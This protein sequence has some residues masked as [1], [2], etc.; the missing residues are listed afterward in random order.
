[1]TATVTALPTP[2]KK[3]ATCAWCHK[4]FERIVDLIDHV[5]SGHLEPAGEVHEDRAAA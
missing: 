1:M 2:S 5:D 3:H 4:D